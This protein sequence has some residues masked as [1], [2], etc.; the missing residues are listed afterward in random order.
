MLFSSE[1]QIYFNF[2]NLIFTNTMKLWITFF[3]STFPL[4]KMND[5]G[6]VCFKKSIWNCVTF[7][8]LFKISVAFF[9]FIYTVIWNKGFFLQS[10]KSQVSN[11]IFKKWFHISKRLL[12][13]KPLKFLWFTTIFSS[14]SRNDLSYDWI[15][16]WIITP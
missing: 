1:R 16:L 13:S 12:A 14:Y 5:S 9:Y 3:W 15:I 6:G 7:C 2:W 10:V 11:L 4:W 8:M